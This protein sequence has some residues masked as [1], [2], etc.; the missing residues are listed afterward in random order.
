MKPKIL[1]A[2]FIHTG[3]HEIEHQAVHSQQSSAPPRASSATKELDDLMASLS[4]FKVCLQNLLPFLLIHRKNHKIAYNLT[5]HFHSTNM[6]IPLLNR[7]LIV[8]LRY[9]L[10]ANISACF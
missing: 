2:F 10:R 4:D 5:S 6:M 1:N 7:Y 3:N 8:G 9:C